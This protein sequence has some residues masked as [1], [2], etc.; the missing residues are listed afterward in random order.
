MLDILGWDVFFP[1]SMFFAAPVFGGSRLAA[2]IRATMITSGVLALGGLS[3]VIAGN[4]QLRNIGIVGYVGV[5]LIV[6]V[7]LAILFYRATPPEP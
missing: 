7:L 3:S 1:L 2:W 5:F 4:M 6:A